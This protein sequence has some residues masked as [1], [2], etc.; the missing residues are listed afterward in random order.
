MM[1]SIHFSVHPHPDG[2][3]MPIIIHKFREALH[4]SKLFEK[5]L[6]LLEKMDAVAVNAVFQFMDTYTFFD[7]EGNKHNDLRK[8]VC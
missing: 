1:E 5:H 7:T 4:T 6:D 2:I 8:W 3:P